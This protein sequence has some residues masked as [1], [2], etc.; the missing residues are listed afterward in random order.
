MLQFDLPVRNAFLIA[1]VA[2]VAL[3]GCGSAGDNGPAI[4]ANSQTIRFEPAPTL[5][6]GETATVVAVASSGLPVRYGSAT[7]GVCRVDPGSGLVTS[8]TLGSCVVSANQAGNSR[9]AQ[10]PEA[11][12][13]LPVA[14]S[15]EQHIT[16]GA[17]P[18]LSLGGTAVVSAT[19]TSGLPVSFSSLSASI[20]SVVP[21]AGVVTALLAGNCV[22]AANQAGDANYH[23]AAQVTQSIVVSAPLSVR[24]PGVPGS[25]TAAPGTVADT[26]LVSF[27][28]TDSGGSPITGYTVTSVPAGI[29]AS[30]T[31]SPITVACPNNCRGYAL[32]VAA[33]N[34]VG[35]GSAS[36]PVPVTAAYQVVETFYEPDT[37]PNNSIFIGTF[38]FNFATGTVSDLK[39]ILSESMTGG[40]TGY[41]SDSMKW[42]SLD[43]QLVSWRDATLGGTFVASFRNAT[44]DTF[45]S[46]ATG[47]SWSPQQGVTVGGRY[48]GSPGANPGNAYALIFVPDDPTATL[49]RAQL[50]MLAYA[51]CAP[52]GMMGDTCMTGTAFAGYG[53]DGTMGG[54]PRS[55]LIAR[56]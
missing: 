24:V 38:T 9:Y 14:F 44:T 51:D 31:A 27:G 18:G 26:V 12:L 10:A 40:S 23:A 13:T 15:P 17:A 36:A 19:A 47:D 43:Y 42:L 30:G 53:S 56:K 21:D 46:S 1:C 54:V 2:S 35:T 4:E 8:L 50:V 22:I 39:G 29:A 37:Q 5:N 20:C 32:S 25:V 6:K 33:Q 52:G 48:Y 16:F 55:Q 45:L 41:P 7:P 34:A 49:T 3:G 28:G 11:T